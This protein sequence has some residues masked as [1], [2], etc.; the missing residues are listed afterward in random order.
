VVQ[1]MMEAVLK[2]AELGEP[3]QLKT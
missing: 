3:T 1:Q 2:S